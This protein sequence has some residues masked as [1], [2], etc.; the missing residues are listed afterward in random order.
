MISLEAPG[1]QH[2]IFNDKLLFFVVQYEKQTKMKGE[3]LMRKLMKI[4]SLLL[5]VTI[6]FGIL[7]ISAFASVSGNDVLI[8]EGTEETSGFDENAHGEV[9][10]TG[11]CGDSANYKFYSDGTLNIFGSGEINKKND[12]P[13]RENILNVYISNGITAIGDS[14]F[15][16]CVNLESVFL[17]SS[18]KIIGKDSFWRCE[19][20]KSIQIPEGTEEIREGAFTLCNEIRDLEIPDVIIFIGKDAFSAC[21][22]IKFFCKSNSIAEWYAIGNFINYELLEGESKN[23]VFPNSFDENEH[24]NI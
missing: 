23:P 18:I 19:K 8:E 16:Y 21:F 11:N 12:F 5:V 1:D 24:G 3:I 9:V 4:I 22:D 7:Y 2:A 6:M 13:T 15:W 20:L 17:P 10:Q 14:T